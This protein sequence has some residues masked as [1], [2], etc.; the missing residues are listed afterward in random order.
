MQSSASP[1]LAEWLDD[2]SV[3]AFL[4]RHFQ[5]A[6]LARPSAA[7]SAMPLLDWNVVERMLAQRVKPDMLVV[8][9]GRLLDPAPQTFAELRALFDRGYSLVLRRTERYDASLAELARTF[10][11]QL[12]GDVSI[13]L[14][15]TPKGFHS[16]GWHYDCEDVFIAQAMGT[17]EYFLRANTV[18]PAPTLDAMPRDMH[19]ERETSPA[20][21]STL[22]AGDWLYVP[23]GWWHVAR[24]HE[25][26]MSISIGILSPA[27]ARAPVQKHG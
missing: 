17:K 15:L 6:P 1:T 25:D 10:A 19:F 21:A 3:D 11:P 8:R 27:A 5:K 4:A 12:D 9:N 2:E 20:V 16:F 22:I 14:Y 26:A 7:K 24:A 18:N 13:Q 23:R